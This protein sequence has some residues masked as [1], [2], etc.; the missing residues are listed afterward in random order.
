MTV[1]CL[2]CGSRF[3]A[4]KGNCKYCTVCRGEIE[5]KNTFTVVSAKLLQLLL[6][7]TKK[8]TTTLSE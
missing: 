7:S 2:V 5:K 1:E 6:Q 4:P 3:V 8:N